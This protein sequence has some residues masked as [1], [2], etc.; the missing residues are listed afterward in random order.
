[1]NQ[2]QP[3]A[4]AREGW[5]MAANNPHDINDVGGDQQQ[6]PL[7][8]QYLRMLIRRRWLIIGAMAV[9]L[10][11][12]LL[13]TLL[14]T[15]QYTATSQIEIQ[16]EADRVTKLDSVQ[17]ETSTNDLE[18]YQTQYGLLKARSLAERVARDLKLA[19]DAQ[20]IETYKLQ[21]KPGVVVPPEVRER[22]LGDI[23][24]GSISVA[25]VRSSSLVAIS[26]TSPNPVLS[27][28]ISNAWGKNFIQA[29]L[30]RRFDS[31]AYARNFLEDRLATL[32]QKMEES[33][34]AL[35]TYAGN[36]QIVNLPAT[37]TTGA[38]Q[39]QTTSEHSIV[40]DDLTALN[41]ELGQA[42]ADRI[43]AQSRLGGGGADSPEA[44]GSPSIAGLRQKRAEAA[45]EYAKTLVQFEP[46]Y[47][48]AQALNQQ[49]K[50]LDAAIAREEGRVGGSIAATYRE[51]S[52]REAALKSRVEGLKSNL[53]DLRRRSIQYN[54]YQRDVD[55]NRE[56]YDG[57]LQ[58]YKEI[59]IA[60]GVGNNNISIVDPADVPQ[61][62]SKPNLFNNL[63][64]ALLLGFAGGVALAFA[65]E[66]MDETITDP[67]D[68]KEKIG[69]PLLGSIPNVGEIEPIVSMADRKSPLVEAYLSFQTSLEFTTPH[70]APRSLAL[71]STRPAEGKSS[72][73]YALAVTLARAK[74][75]VVL[76]DCD[77]RSPSVH[78]M[79]GSNNEMG[80]SNYL[81][82]HDRVED[83]L[84]GSSE[85]GLSVITAGPQP[86]NA[87][88]LLTGDRL[89]QLIAALLKS[90]D[91]VVVD[92]PPVM[93]LADAPLIASKVE[94]TIFV[95]ESHGIRRSLVHVALDRLRAANGRLAGV[96]LTKFDAKRAHYG[97]GYDYGYGYGERD[98]AA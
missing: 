82:G 24:L 79:V 44:I 18:F 4:D 48:A 95:V 21:A 8:T 2:F 87:A 69:L 86:P 27:A 49:I 92:S 70:G 50:Q 60:G 47:P 98:Q 64:L 41:N 15:K 66:Q 19:T 57:L 25:P 39:S 22:Q 97:Y 37:T 96:L 58:R 13:A 84:H 88:E 31:A 52:A 17:R 43:K 54:I 36:Q 67:A 12:G 46:G 14:T 74:R 78:Y 40:A 30:E 45:A 91:H 59:G 11:L 1:M 35:V 94:A 16:R 28:R 9:A 23:L 72:S 63:A 33:E 32:R 65:R 3:A 7:L 26:Y 83:L 71:T 6:L 81:T 61:G 62:P 29:N 73:A 93:G 75:R 76:I 20:F 53:L 42:T 90:Y 56:L 55:T 89:D 34:R 5:D 68:V 51:A 10:V 38:G 77:M 80:V 85:D